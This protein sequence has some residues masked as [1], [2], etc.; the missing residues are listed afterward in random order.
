[1]GKSKIIRLQDH[2][3]AH[4]YDLQSDLIQ[5]IGLVDALD[6]LPIENGAV[7]YMINALNSSIDAFAKNFDRLLNAID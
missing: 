2:H 1:M 6:N 5:I 3:L 7:I 4:L